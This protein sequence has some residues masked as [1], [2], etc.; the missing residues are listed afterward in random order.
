MKKIPLLLPPLSGDG[1]YPCFW[2]LTSYEDVVLE[3][4]AFFRFR[5]HRKGIRDRLRQGETSVRY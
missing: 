5:R 2:L 3:H 4:P 1:T